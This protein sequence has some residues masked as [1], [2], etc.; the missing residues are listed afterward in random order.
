MQQPYMDSPGECEFN[1]LYS[2]REDLANADDPMPY[3]DG[4][5]NGRKRLT[6]RER[7]ISCSSLAEIFWSFS[8]VVSG[9]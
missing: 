9:V 5:T 8:T 6:S 3:G 4:G 1:S 2:R 7:D